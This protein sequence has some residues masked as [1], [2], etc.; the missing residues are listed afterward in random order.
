MKQ[1]TI[2]QNPDSKVQILVI[3]QRSVSM[4][5]CYLYVLILTPSTVQNRTEINMRY[6]KGCLSND[7]PRSHLI[8]CP[9]HCGTKF[10]ECGPPAE[11]SLRPLVY[12][13]QVYFP[14]AD[15]IAPDTEH[16]G[17]TDADGIMPLECPDDCYRN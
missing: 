11:E 7:N 17:D 4:F 5:I 8:H 1:E 14:E 9:G 15:V 3:L 16:H 12:I 13:N 6:G 2:F 10:R